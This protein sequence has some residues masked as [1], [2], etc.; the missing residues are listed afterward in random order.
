MTKLERL[1]K[2]MYEAE[3]VADVLWDELDE[4]FSASFIAADAAFDKAHD[5]YFNE[6]EKQQN[7]D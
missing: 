4:S 3:I 6:L 5:A 2:E 1:R 7:N